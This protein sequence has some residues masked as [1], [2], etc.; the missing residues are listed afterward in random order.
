MPPR[1]WVVTVSIYSNQIS[2]EWFIIEASHIRDPFLITAQQS[3]GKEPA[4]RASKGP[5]EPDKPTS[6]MELFGGLL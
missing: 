1:V 2:V 4:R 6:K 5:R 3:S